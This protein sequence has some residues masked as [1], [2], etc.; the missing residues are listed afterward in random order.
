MTIRTFD[1]HTPQVDDSAYV[2]ESAVVIGNVKIGADASI[3]PCAVARGDVNYIHIGA[4]TNVQDGSILHVVHANAEFTSES[5]AAL[6]IGDDV[7]VGH[8]VVLHACQIGNRCL[9]GMGAIVMDYSVVEDEV[10]IAAGSVVPPGKTLESGHL[11][12]GNPA[13]KKRPLTEKEKT[14]LAYSAKNYVS[15]SKKFK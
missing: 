4:R 14:F 11:Y 12:L 6:V 10:M 3:W 13:K 5:G 9:V 7:T 15:L 8:N 2:D 1:G